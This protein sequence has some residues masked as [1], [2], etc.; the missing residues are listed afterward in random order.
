M[1]HVSTP[2]QRDRL[3]LLNAL[4]IVLLALLGAA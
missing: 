4:A 2:T 3:G 1:I